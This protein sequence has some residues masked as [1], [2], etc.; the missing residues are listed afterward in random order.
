MAG[1]QDIFQQAMNEG[2]SAAWDQMWD[3]AASYYRQALEEFPDHPQ[4]LTNLGLAYIELQDFEGALNCYLQVSRLRPNDPLPVEKVAQIYERMGSLD[5]AAQASLRAAELYLKKR[6]VKKAIENWERV[7]R[8]NPDN[9][10]AYSR[11]ALVY[12]RIE[13]KEK[14]V[15]AYLALAS[16]MQSA[17]DIEKA[18]SAAKRALTIKPDS[19]EVVGALELLKDQKPL[20]KPERPRGGTAPLRMSQVRQLEAPAE[21]LP[22]ERGLDPIAQARQ[23]ALT[24]MAGILFEGTED[25]K[26]EDTGRRDLQQ[27]VA[28]NSDSTRE[29]SSDHGRMILH[30]S[31]VID[32]QTQG[33]TIH[34]ADEL[35]R[36]M[37]LG[38]E[39]SAAFF[40]LGYLHAQNGRRESAM[41][42]LQRAVQHVDFALGTRLLL[43][44]LYRQK[45]DF[46]AAAIEYLEALKLADVQMVTAEQAN[47]LRQLYEPIIDGQRNME[48]QEA[49]EQLCNNIQELLI[50]PNWQE[51]M[52]SRAQ[53]AP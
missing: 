11:M 40:D 15:S 39:H 14:A 8:L 5:P 50:R 12:E 32:L 18:T 2:H 24:V 3:Q 25:K 27:I 52:Q 20:P 43:G 17:G 31:Q 21:S 45:G 53:A 34:A 28:G 36:A 49:Q 6:D 4:A 1:R 13:D 46:R 37:E 10:Q 41:R 47:D 44:D 23:K 38:L 33:D 30:L 7:T 35:E 29:P 19:K 42:Q 16:L 48:D 22:A 26:E 9:I 51:Q